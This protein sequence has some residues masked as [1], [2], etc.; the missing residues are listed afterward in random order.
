MEMSLKHGQKVQTQY[1]HRVQHQWYGK[2]NSYYCRQLLLFDEYRTNT[3]QMQHEYVDKVHHVIILVI[4]LNS[5]KIVLIFL[6]VV[7]RFLNMLVGVVK[8]L[9]D[10]VK[11]IEIIKNLHIVYYIFVVFRVNKIKYQGLRF[12]FQY[13]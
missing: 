12:D 9:F 7:D 6:L 5:H 8:L 1:N 10:L 3:Q 13:V 11:Y 2:V 4:S